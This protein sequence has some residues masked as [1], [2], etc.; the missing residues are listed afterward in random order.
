MGV[1]KN[2]KVWWEV[3]KKTGIVYYEFIKR[4][5]KR[6]LIHE[7]RCDERLKTKSEESTRLIYT[8]LIG[9]LELRNFVC[10]CFCL[11]WIDKSRG[12]KKTNILAPLKTSSVHSLQFVFE[13]HAENT[14]MVPFIWTRGSS[15]TRSSVLPCGPSIRQCCRASVRC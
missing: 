4:E 13:E 5:L 12:E 6:R 14:S 3:Y 1:M 9:G 10:L 7:C 11:L 8:W 2:A 15:F